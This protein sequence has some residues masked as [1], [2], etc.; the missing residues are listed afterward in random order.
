MSR[1]DHDALA[2]AQVDSIGIPE[3]EPSFLPDPV[4]DRLLE[5]LIALGGELWV[6]R[7]QRVRLEAAL[8]AK[9]VVTQEEIDACV[10]GENERG[11]QREALNA[12]VKRLFGPLT[13]LPGN[14]D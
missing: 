8:I 5:A 12:M 11:A 9:G 13:S 2:Q 4:N 1:E 3:S 14:N 7:E 10:L 6:E